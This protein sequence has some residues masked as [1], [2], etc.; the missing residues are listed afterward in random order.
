[1][2]PSAPPKGSE[3]RP[4]GRPCVA[5]TALAGYW[6]IRRENTAAC[7]DC[8]PRPLPN[9]PFPHNQDPKRTLHSQLKL[10]ILLSL[11]DRI[12]QILA[13]FVVLFAFADG[14]TRKV[15]LIIA[16]AGELDFVLDDLCL[17]AC[18]I[19]FIF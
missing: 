8:R 1:M 3:L 9:Y 14:L 13:P 10:K 15:G 17:D 4:K 16:M 18:W 5:V 6:T 7:N 11:L 12:A 2:Q 19:E